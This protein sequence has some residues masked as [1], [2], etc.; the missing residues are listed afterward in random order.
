[1]KYILIAVLFISGFVSAQT[2]KPLY[3][4]AGWDL[5]GSD[6]RMVW[7]TGSDTIFKVRIDSLVVKKLIV[8]NSAYVLTTNATPTTIQT[9]TITD[10]TAGVIQVALS[11]K[12][13]GTAGA[14][15]GIKA[16]QYDKNG[17]TLTLGTVGDVLATTA[18]GTMA[19]ATWT[20]TSASNQIIVQVT[21]VAATNAEW[22]CYVTQTKH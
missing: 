16:V 22:T 2:S 12:E 21:G 9:I 7:H 14:I 11:G 17:G 5:L 18:T 1:M 6:R 3:G 8:G 15:G 13:T 10:E 4:R 19:T 20:I